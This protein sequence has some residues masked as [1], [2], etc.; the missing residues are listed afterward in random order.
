MSADEFR[1]ALAFSGEFGET[2]NITIEEWEESDEGFHRG[3]KFENYIRRESRGLIEVHPASGPLAQVRFIHGSVSTFLYTHT[4]LEVLGEGSQLKLEQRY[5]LVLLE[6]CFRALSFCK[7]RGEETTKFIDYA[8]ENWVHHAR[9]C[10]ELLQ[11]LEKLPHFLDNCTGSKTRRVIDQQIQKLKQ[12]SAKEWFL[13]D[14]EKSLLV[15]L[16]TLGCTNLLQR[17]LEDCL[18]C[19]DTCTEYTG[20][21]GPYRK[22]LQNAIISG[23]TDTAKWLLQTHCDGDI[24]S[25]YNDTTLLYKACYFGHKEV[26]TFLLAH[27]ANPLVRCF[28][29]YEYALHV[30][31]ELGH[32]EIV[33]ELLK[34]SHTN[35]EN[36]LKTRR[37]RDGS[38]ALHTAIKSLQ[39]ASRKI[40]VLTTLLSYAPK[41]IGLLEV[42]DEQGHSPVALAQKVQEEGFEA[43]D[44][45]ED[46][47]DV[48]YS[49]DR[50]AARKKQADAK[51]RGEIFELGTKGS[52]VESGVTICIRETLSS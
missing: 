23:W 48:F 47:L 11:D 16:A 33:R 9:G 1:H 7:L 13:L 51:D 20:E 40:P 35:L 25:L 28:R 43:A 15:L 34:S 31:I 24:N 42:L 29:R 18:S 26:V 32:E 27:G 38:T 39:S 52:G 45:I 49:A 30:A 37:K 50:I 12:A 6:I 21:P 2:S 41:G 5:H 3:D 10:G 36:L 19:K 14:G 44:D 4:A 17:H 8:C 46:E 22:A